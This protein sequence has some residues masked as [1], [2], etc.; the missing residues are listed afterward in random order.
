[1]PKLFSSR[2]IDFIL[3]HEGFIF[4]S[5]KGSHAKYRKVENGLTLTVI[6][7]MNQKEIPRG[8]FGSILRQSNLAKE[9]FE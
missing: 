8:T 6:L 1:M 5:Q 2:H 4:I 3:T 9:D 7:P